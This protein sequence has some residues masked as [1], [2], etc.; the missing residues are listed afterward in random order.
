MGKNDSDTEEDDSDNEEEKD[1]STVSNNGNSSDSN[2]EADGSLD[3]VT[4]RKQDGENSGR[5]SCESGSEE[6]KELV[7][8][9]VQESIHTEKN[10]MVE[11]VIQDEKIATSTSIPCSAPD[12]VVGVEAM[13]DE[14]MGCNGTEMG[15]VE[16]VVSQLQ[17]NSNSGDGQG[18]ESTSIVSE[19][20]GSSESNPVVQEET[21]ANG[22]TAEIEKP[23][24]FDEFNSAA[25][26]E[27]CMWKL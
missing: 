23:L 4:G 9:T 7:V 6:E 21:V 22:N 5:S 18:V 3:S 12:A 10:D 19:A 26:M 24:N 11:P 14:K 20:N 1:K 17:K 2:K 8:H 15:N 27:V 16:D 13:Q 25:E